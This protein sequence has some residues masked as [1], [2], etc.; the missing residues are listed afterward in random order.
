M[1]GVLDPF[2][3]ILIAVAGWVNHSQLQV[4]DYLNF[5]IARDPP[6]ICKLPRRRRPQR[7]GRSTT[8]SMKAYGITTGDAIKCGR[9]ALLLLASRGRWST[10][11]WALPN[12]VVSGWSLVRESGGGIQSESRMRAIRT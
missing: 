9:V 3:F 2:R 10:A 5:R 1:C 12:C 6:L 4:I 8:T 7:I 11:G